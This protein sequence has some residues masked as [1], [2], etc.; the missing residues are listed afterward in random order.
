MHSR[1]SQHRHGYQF[2]HQNIKDATTH[3]KPRQHPATASSG[4]SLTRMIRPLYKPPS[5]KCSFS[6]RQRG[7]LG[8]LYQLE[9]ALLQFS[10][11]AATDAL[12]RGCLRSAWRRVER[13]VDAAHF[14]LGISIV[15]AESVEA[16]EVVDSKSRQ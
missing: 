4:C 8:S 5:T 15:R 14:P 1:S 6:W 3:Q 16:G 2:L 11:G 12:E 9:F 13:A 10:H 7:S